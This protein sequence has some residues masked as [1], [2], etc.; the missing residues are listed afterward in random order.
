MA[1]ELGSLAVKI[2]LDSTGFQSGVSDINKS[3]KVLESEF[4]ANTAALGDHAKGIEGAKLKY[5]MLTKSMDLQKQKVAA[6]ESAYQKSVETKGKDARAT[7]DLAIKLNNAKAD[8]SKMDGALKNANTDLVEAESKTNKFAA[9]ADKMGLNVQGVKTAFGAV[10]L[11]AAGYLKGAIDSA[12]GAEQSTTK[13]TNILKNQGLSASDA[14]TKIKEFQKKITDMSDFSAG[15]AKEALQTLTEKGMGVGDS[16]KWAGT[17]ADVASGSNKSLS[18]SADLVADAY[19]GKAKALV[20][21][22]ILSKA[23]VK[24]LGTSETSTITM[25]EVQKRLNAQFGG[26]SAAV[27]GTYAGKM[28]ENENTIKSAKT[29]IGTAMLPVLAQLAE[30]LAKIIVPLADFIKAN[31]QFTAAVLAIVAVLGTL[32]GGLSVLN[33]VTTAMGTLGTVFSG[34]GIAAGGMILPVLAVVAAIALVAFAAYEIIKHWAQI[35]TF[36]SGLWAGIKKSFSDAV[37]GMTSGS[38]NFVDGVKR[39][40]EDMKTKAIAVWNSIK[41]APGKAMEAAKATVSSKIESIKTTINDKIN[42]IKTI[43]KNMFSGGITMPSLKL[44]HMMITG[45]LSLNPPSIPTLGVKWYDKGGVFNSP[46][47]IGVGEKRPEFVGALDDLRYLIRDEMNKKAG[48]K[49]TTV[50][51]Y[52]PVAEKSS[53]STRKQLTRLAYMG[54]V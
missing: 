44:P 1:E 18:E 50:N 23:E 31:P 41:E 51:I 5:E 47:V 29:A 15:E 48:D 20:A 40:W 42:A 45:K 13:L 24:Q 17:V 9:A 34:A 46:S 7:Q 16:L 49:S 33:T 8:L 21:L 4:K 10:G 11:A 38:K 27:L 22:G 37:A 36:F 2:G 54:V 32:I 43:F 14:G 6:L 30:A 26:S 28:K 12:T 53:E 52:N 3:M 25:T 19:N 35:K 39:G